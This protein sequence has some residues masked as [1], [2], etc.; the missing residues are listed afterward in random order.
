MADRTDPGA[1]F[2]AFTDP[3]FFAWTSELIEQACQHLAR[4]ADVSLGARTGRIDYA[5]RFLRIAVDGATLEICLYATTAN[6]RYNAPEQ[7][8]SI[9]LAERPDRQ[10]PGWVQEDLMRRGASKTRDLAGYSSFR[11]RMDAESL[12]PGRQR[13]SPAEDLADWVAEFLTTLSLSGRRTRGSS[14]GTSRR[15]PC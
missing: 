9:W 6:G 1:R 12:K 3:E 5:G 7:G 10:F 14:A 8:D 11:M 13:V 15:S 4:R 2:D